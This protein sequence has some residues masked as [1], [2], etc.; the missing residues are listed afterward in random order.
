MPEIITIQLN[1]DVA[2]VQAVQTHL[3]QLYNDPEFSTLF[4]RPVLSLMD[5]GCDYLITNL[6]L[7]VAK[8]EARKK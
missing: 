2:K 1:D 7:L 5:A 3:R 8:F 6:R 4:N